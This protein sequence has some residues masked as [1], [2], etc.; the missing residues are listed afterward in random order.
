MG[1]YYDGLRHHVCARW[2][3]QAGSWNV[4]LDGIIINNGSGKEVGHTIP[5][6]GYLVIGQEQDNPAG[7]PSG[8]SLSQSFVGIISG[9]NVWSEVLT[10]DEIL[11]MSKTCNMGSGDVLKWSDFQIWRHGDVQV[12]CPSTC[13]V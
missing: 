9:M 7:D 13:K 6:R 1:N 5:G 10:H 8:F 4:T 2:E 3:N 11:R 12:K